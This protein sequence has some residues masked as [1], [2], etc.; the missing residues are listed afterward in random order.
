MN[1]QRLL[2]WLL[3]WSLLLFIAI[4]KKTESLATEPE[5]PQRP[6]NVLFI[7]VDDLRVELGCLRS[8]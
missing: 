1:H 5:V 6:K 2:R 4:L 7:A 3:S 8:N